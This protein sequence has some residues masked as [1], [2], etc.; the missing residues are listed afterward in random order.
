[1]IP[2]PLVPDWPSAYPATGASARCK[3]RPEDFRVDEQLGF[4]PDGAGE[5]LL[6]RLC[7]TALTT[8][9]VVDVLCRQLGVAP[10]AVGYA[11]LKD[12]LAVARQWFSVH[13]A[14]DAATASARLQDVAGL[15]LEECTR[16][17]RKLRRGQIA[18]NAFEIVLRDV[19]GEGW[20]ARLALI[21]GNGAPNYFGPQRFGRDN[22]DQAAAWLAQGRRRRLSRFRQGL[23]LSVLRSFLFN[24]VLAARIRDGSWCVPLEGESVPVAALWGRG[25][26]LAV[27]DALALEQAALAPWAALRDGLEHA[28]LVQAQRRL[29]LLPQN[30]QWSQAGADLSLSFQLPPGG[31]ATTL[32]GEAFALSLPAVAGR[33]AA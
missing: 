25:R 1:M 12:K 27:G 5:H 4:E 23:Y 17:G 18:G 29:V 8:R 19:R 13:T 11:G 6:L 32:L 30:L 33:E 9:E 10:V 28:G 15:Q 24:E 20:Q 16:N 7:K 3:V 31:Y 14:L 26:S 22:L 2:T 21:A